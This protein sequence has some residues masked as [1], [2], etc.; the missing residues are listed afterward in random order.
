MNVSFPKTIIHRI[1]TIFKSARPSFPEEEKEIAAVITGLERRM[2]MYII[3]RFTSASMLWG[4]GIAIVLIS[5]SQFVVIPIPMIFA[6]AAILVI[7]LLAGIVKGA[8]ARV[9][10]LEA[11]IA[12]DA[13]L[14][15]KERLSS[16]TELLRQVDRTE[17][18]ELQLED[19]ANYA[20][21]LDP[22]AIC[23]RVF[24]TTAKILP[25]AGL[26]MI[27]LM[28]I[29]LHYSQSAGIPAEVRQAIKQAGAE[30]EM[31]AGQV[32]KELLSDEVAKLASEMAIT[33]REFQDKP[34][35]KKEAL[36]DL[37]N[38]AR[39]IEALEMMARIAKELE[40]DMTPEKKRILNELLEK[41][42]DNLKD[43]RGMEGFSQKVLEAQQADLSIEALKELSAALEEMRIGA[44]DMKALKQMSDQVAEG[45][46]DIRQTT[47]AA[48]R[49]MGATGT[50]EKEGTGRMGSGSPGKDTA[51]DTV[52]TAAHSARQ[53]IP[54]D[55]GYDSELEGQLS[56]EGRSVPTEIQ[57][58]LEKGESLVPYEEIY[59]K[60]RDAADD[61][62]TRTMIPW[63]HRQHVKSYFDAIRPKEK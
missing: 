3:W 47:L 45:K 10:A 22:K 34:L 11:A 9:S 51:K 18:A 59:V 63:S 57:V 46:R 14:G 50:Q 1:S 54:S 16:A 49:G 39:E 21:S 35:T 26:A 36:K 55:T 17:M 24:P 13:Q 28:Y 37:S 27:F 7:S 29:S 23:P 38:V 4:M 42:A 48:K 33:G 44:S 61:A 31:A 52:E 20:R 2:N 60:Y 53:P 12:A 32:D 40:S 6:V 62:I 25:L 15:L 58:D 30:M 41:L 8:L 5:I 56:Q 43:I 19:A